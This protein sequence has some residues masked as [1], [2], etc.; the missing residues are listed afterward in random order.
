[1]FKDKLFSP[2]FLL[3]MLVLIKEGLV[4]FGLSP[5]TLFLNN[6][7]ISDDVWARKETVNSRKLEYLESREKYISAMQE[8]KRE[9]KIAQ[10]QNAKAISHSK[11]PSYSSTKNLNFPYNQNGWESSLAGV[12]WPSGPS[13]ATSNAAVASVSRGAA[14]GTWPPAPAGNPKVG[15][16][17]KESEKVSSEYEYANARID[18][19]VANLQIVADNI[20]DLRNGL[21]YLA[22]NESNPFRTFF[23]KLLDWVVPI[24]LTATLQEHVLTR[25]KRIKAL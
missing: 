11:T 22:H 9:N 17:K 6:Q 15:F 23:L 18:A 24:V 20:N 7:K 10:K 25:L 3:A 14:V 21:K 12:N 13:G 1:M 4:I 19:L 5:S 2:I 16:D 8:V